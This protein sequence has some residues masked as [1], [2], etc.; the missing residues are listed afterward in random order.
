MLFPNGMTA[1]ACGFRPVGP[2]DA[3]KAARPEA[4]CLVGPEAVSLEAAKAAHLKDAK[5][6][7]PEAVCLVG[8]EAARVGPDVASN[9]DVV[10]DG[11]LDVV[12]STSCGLLSPDGK[13]FE[14]INPGIKRGCSCINF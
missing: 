4:V 12:R 9:A 8:P 6:A 13:W 1:G 11:G 3:A 7:R 10:L 14:P 5:A 2:V